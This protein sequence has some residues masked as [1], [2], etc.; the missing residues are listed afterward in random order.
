MKRNILF[1]CKY[2]RFRSKIA[3]AIFKKLNKNRNNR[4]KSAG[5]IK[6]NPIDTIQKNLGLRFR[7]NIKN[8][9][10][11]VS[12]KL[13]AW[14]DIIV[15]VADDVPISLFIKSKKYGKK[16]I[17]WK[18]QDTKSDDKKEIEKVIKIIEKR[19]KLFIK[20]LK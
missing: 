8:P 6:G 4:V 10:R 1:I 11:G 16:L 19:V 20:N 13:L 15:I 7:I 17:I 18:I 2:N 5:I 9:T 12:S 14:S 3:E